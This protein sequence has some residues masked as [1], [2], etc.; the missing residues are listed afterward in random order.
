[1]VLDHVSQRSSLLVIASAILYPQA[2]G[3]GDLHVVNV[4]SIPKGL[5]DAVGKAQNNDVLNGFFAQ[6]VIDAINLVFLQDL[7]DRLIKRYG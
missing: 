4:S 7:M 6:I 2:L 1:M 5:K 3:S